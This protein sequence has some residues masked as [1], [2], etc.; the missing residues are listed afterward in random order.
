MYLFL[1]ISIHVISGKYIATR[2]HIQFAVEC[3]T[4]FI[5]SS[6]ISDVGM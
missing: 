3:L 1:K 2:W 4:V 6:G 5:L